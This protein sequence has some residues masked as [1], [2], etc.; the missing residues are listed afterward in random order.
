M[1]PEE[2]LVPRFAAEPSQQ[3]APHGD[4]EQQLRSE[5]LTACLAIPEELGDP[6]DVVFFPDRT[7]SG[8]TY[9]PATCTT[10][11]EL[12][13][14]G[15][16]SFRPGYEDDDEH[17]SFLA[18]ADWTDETAAKNPDW[19]IDL[20]DEV[21]GGWRGNHGEVAAMTAI[22]G[23]PMITG[24]M[25]ATAELGGVVVDQCVLVD[26]RFTLIAPDAYRGNTLEV[27]LHDSHGAELTRESLYADDED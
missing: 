19:K 1:P 2:L 7:W 24:A 6:G 20:C 4:W 22:W 9:Q 25:T 15:L 5:F 17:E 3:P 27:A 10:S 23:T 16:V 21:V 18:T 8:R 14:F 26:N 13:L 12:D 11:S